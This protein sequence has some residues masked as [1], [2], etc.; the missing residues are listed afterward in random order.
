MTDYGL[1]RIRL[2]K[3]LDHA[4]TVKSLQPL[5]ES[6]ALSI[7]KAKHAEP[8]KQAEANKAVLKSYEEL[9]DKMASC[10]VRNLLK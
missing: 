3:P 7:S 8:Y 2:R 4:A 10:K 9:M 1:Y 6:L 5:V